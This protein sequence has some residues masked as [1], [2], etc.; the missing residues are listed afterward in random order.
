MVEAAFGIICKTPQAGLSKTRLFPLL[1]KKGAAQI[2]S[3]FLSDIAHA[4]NMVPEAAGR[5]GYAVYAPKGT[6]A[7]LAPLLPS[8]FGLLCRRDA[9]LGVV[10][11]GATEQLLTE[12]HDCVILV[13]GDS[14]TMP[15]LLFSSALAALRAPGER[16]VL[17]PTID[18]G[19]YLIGLKTPYA[20]LF[21]DIPWSTSQVFAKTVE[22]A[23][24]IGLDVCAL[25]AWYDIDDAESFAILKKEI[26]GQALDFNVTGLTGGPAYATR[27][28]LSS[29]QTRSACSPGWWSA[30]TGPFST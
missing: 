30:S 18:G 1:G 10:L 24:D 11:L 23:K 27:K 17:G 19:Y 16:V 20:A 9:T 12:G 6:E 14:P 4:I 8:D 29:R 21:E 15:P 28:F 22:R 2:A 5:R 25:P 13:N 7:I 3:A 26:E